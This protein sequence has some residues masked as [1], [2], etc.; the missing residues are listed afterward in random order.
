MNLR[1]IEALHAVLRTG[2]VGQAARLLAVSQPAV[3]KLIRHA[4]QR[5]GFQLFE[6]VKGRLIPT[7]ELRMLGSEISSLFG[8]LEH[9][10][11]LARNVVAHAEGRLRLG[12]SHSL[13]LSVVPHVIARFQAR[14]PNISYDLRT[15]HTAEL[16]EGLRTQEID[17]ALTFDPDP[18]P[19]VGIRSQR[20]GSAELVYV[21]RGKHAQEV[22]LDEIATASL[23]G[24]TDGD[25]I[26]S[27]LDRKL[28]D[29][30]IAL[31]PSIR[32]QTY[33]IACALV[34]NGCGNAIVDQFTAD[35]MRHQGISVVRIRP[36]IAFK[37]AALSNDLAVLPT[38]C[39]EFLKAARGTISNWHLA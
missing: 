19:H 14:Y 31:R 18:E 38:F 24:L 29:A 3:S 33:Y 39:T 21:T 22:H 20:L 37:I 7:Q 26:G 32:V 10:R 12:S 4:E 36:R 5:I 13:G 17:L 15:Q 25:P 16:I 8:Q 11:R 1:H 34:A 23:I 9:F 30:N 2:S 6:R 28:R 27:L 35:A